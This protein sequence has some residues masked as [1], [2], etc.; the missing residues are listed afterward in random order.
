MN[1]NPTEKALLA[2]ALQILAAIFGLFS[3][4]RAGLNDFSSYTSYSLG[5]AWPEAV[6]IGDVNHDGRNDVVLCTS[7]YGG[8]NRN[9]LLVYCQ[10]E[11]GQL[12]APVRY[13]A[14]AAA[15]AVV[16]ADL[17]GDGLKDVAIGQKS[18]GVRV[19]Y[20]DSEGTLQ[21]FADIATDYAYSLCAGDF[22][23]DGLCD[24]AGI[25][26][27]GGFVDVW[28]QT[29]QGTLARMGQYAA[30]Y[31]GYNDLKAADVNGDGW[32]DI[33]VCSGQGAGPDLSLL[34]QTNGGF[35]EPVY[36]NLDGSGIPGGIGIGNAGGV[37]RNDLVLSYGGNRP[38]S[39][40]RVFRQQADGTFSLGSPMASYDIPK[41][42]FVLDV[43]MNGLEDIV[44]AHSGW[45]RV[46]VYYQAAPGVFGTEQIF[47]TG[48][49]ASAYG[50]AAMAV[51]DFT[52]DDMPDIALADRSA[53]L[54]ILKNQL[55]APR[56]R[57]SGLTRNKA[58]QFVVSSRF[59]G[60]DG[61]CTVRTSV[62]LANW[63]NAGVMN[64][65]FWIDTNSPA[66]SSRFYRLAD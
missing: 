1:T 58:G 55:A 9:S 62:D 10:S 54:V 16:I 49:A 15:Y 59:R 43:D 30:S 53:G 36:L 18:S 7:N 37:G 8:T 44:V 26:W 14:A 45:N 20:Q 56:L 38:N 28:Q 52:G 35:A 24:L 3:R 46:G 21:S 40:V 42:V 5:V 4:A 33:V 23:H 31:N 65:S 66:S 60:P 51:G 34:L 27:S 47:L 11:T 50:P 13:S 32:C 41:A 29:T 2:R 22:N 12:Q 25:G 19:F 64:G 63:T 48:T 39:F 6:A 61:R 57:I 17:N